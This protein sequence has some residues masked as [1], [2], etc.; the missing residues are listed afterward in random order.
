MAYRTLDLGKTKETLE[1]LEHRITERFPDSSLALVARELNDIALETESKCMWI[2]TPN[3]ALRLAVGFLIVFLALMLILG[4][5]TVEFEVGSFPMTDFIQALEAGINDLV[6]MGAAVFFLVSIESR[7]KRARALQSL[8]E[9]RTIAHVIDMHQL[10]KDPT[11][12]HPDAR[13]TS[14]SPSRD[15]DSYELNRYLD[16]CSEL[17][18]L[19]GK[20]ASIYAQHF[21]DGTVV[22][23]VNDVETLT[24]GLSR[25][26]W[27][28][29]FLIREQSEPSS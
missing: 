6:L 25:K 21:P 22:S 20:L 13:R 18:S 27:Q 10:T 3:R 7:I 14:S 16:Y 11:E 28:K 2:A 24:T 9:L 1:R 5:T 12:L 19:V 15:M 26:I 8:N 29:I 23:A 17:L 4:F